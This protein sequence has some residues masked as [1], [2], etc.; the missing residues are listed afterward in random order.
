MCIYLPTRRVLFTGDIMA[1][2][3]DRGGNMVL[4]P[5]IPI[6]TTD[7]TQA[8]ESFRK[9]DGLDVDVI[10]SG[11]WQPILQNGGEKI[12]ALVEK[13]EDQVKE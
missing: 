13:P 1:Q 8:K 4:K 2:K 3:K 11:H 10:C 9:L 5:P 6:F 7:M 12:Q